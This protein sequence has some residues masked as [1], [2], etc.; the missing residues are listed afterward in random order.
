MKIQYDNHK[1]IF[2]N[3]S[4]NK[5]DNSEFITSNKLTID[6]W[7]QERIRRNIDPLCDE[8]KTKKW[9]TL[10]DGKYGSDAI[11]ISSK[12]VKNI[13]AT[14]LNDTLL[15]ISFQ[16]KLIKKY[17]KQNAEKIKFSNQ[18]F[19]ISLCKE[20]F[21]HFPRPILALY[22]MLRISKE[23][24]I[25]I[26][27]QDNLSLINLFKN[28]YQFEEVGNFVYS[29]SI[30]E[31]EKIMMGIGLKSYAFKEINDYYKEGIESICTS[32]KSIKN[33]IIFYKFKTIILIKD[34]LVKLKIK[35]SNLITIVIFK[36]NPSD[37]LREKLLKSGYHIKNLP[38][39]PYSN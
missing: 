17:S 39:N 38:K 4:K 1:K 37:K 6:S 24:V 26:E 7:R 3:I 35:K 12:G 27:P 33:K 14:D 25:L 22:E 20:A 10:G 31:I 11:Y 2:D 16:K 34:I 29:L 13:I 18:H 19:D 8:Y 21:H 36:H 28:K 30:N 15:K 32:D 9:I 23:A 5:I